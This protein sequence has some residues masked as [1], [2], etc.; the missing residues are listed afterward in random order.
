M[1]TEPVNVDAILNQTVGY[2]F[3]GVSFELL[4]VSVNILNNVLTSVCSFYGVS[5][6]QTVYY[7]HEY[8]HD[9]FY[10]RALVNCHIHQ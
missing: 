6:A 3:I 9:H 8:Q 4:Y 2:I 10:I 7:Y 5:L 1:A